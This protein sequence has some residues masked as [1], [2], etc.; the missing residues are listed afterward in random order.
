MRL[1][2]CIPPSTFL[3]NDRVFPYLGPVQVA[4]AAR[5]LAGWDVRV[6]DLTGHAL[7]CSAPSSSTENESARGALIGAVSSQRFE[8]HTAP[9]CVEEVWRNAEREIAAAPADVYGFYALS[10]QVHE[11][12]RLLDLVRRHWPKARTVLGGPHVAMA[13]DAAALLGFDHV[14]ADLGGGGGGEAPF[15]RLLR[16][17]SL[18]LDVPKIVRAKPGDATLAHWPWPDRSLI[19]IRSYDYRLLGEKTATIVSQRGCSYGCDFCS[20]TQF[21][22]R[23]EFRDI[24]HVRAELRELR[25]TYGYRA[26][27]LYDDE[28]NLRRDHFE[29]LCRAL[30]EGGW[31][32]R[33]FIKSNLFTDEQAR[34][35]AE[36]GAVQLCTGAESA[37][38][39]IKHNI[40]K[41]STIDDDTRFVQ[42]CLKYS[43]APKC[44]S[45]LGVAGESRDT[46]YE[47]RDW[48]LARV[49]DGLVDFDVTV[50]TPYPGTEL[51]DA[52][53]AA[54]EY[55]PSSRHGL[56]LVKRP[57]FAGSTVHYK[58]R[59]GAYVAMTETFDPSTGKVLCT[60]ADLVALRDEVDRDVRAAVMK[61]RARSVVVNAAGEG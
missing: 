25:E 35:A 56:R 54:G 30:H 51:Y 59:P 17:I 44:F 16:R 53:M 11:T 29:A 2:V 50:M 55:K 10:C 13:P 57:D 8:D 38:A 49:E 9:D 34:M 33:C 12:M 26:V 18:G 47:L 19:D 42:L 15:L 14:V 22:R 36:S 6:L 7:R 48:L 23:V 32:W 58:T 31:I 39:E 4:T 43:I 28:T 46:A 21:Y 37:N 40:K 5:D 60:S 3:P 20:H 24:D 45:M 41:K 52:L 27:M 61:R 1:A